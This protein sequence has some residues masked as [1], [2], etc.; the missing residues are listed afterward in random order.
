[1]NNSGTF[2]LASTAVLTVATFDVNE[3]L[4]LEHAETFAGDLIQTNNIDLNGFNL[5]LTGTAALDSSV[6]GGGTLTVAG[7]ADVNGLYLYDDAAMVV[8]GTVTQDGGF[9]MGNSGTD[10]TVL[11]IASGAVFDLL[12]DNSINANGT[13]VIHNAGLF[14]KA[15]DYGTS[16][17]YP[18]FDSTGTLDVVRGFLNIQSRGSLS[19]PIEGAQDGSVARLGSPTKAPASSMLPTA[20]SPSRAA[21]QPSAAR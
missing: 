18:T 11:S 9:T 1:M 20:R 15:G 3:S 4:V 5:S 12:T 7:K 14:E 19:G 8:K 10:N 21:G 6:Q 13:A 17:I 2:S 16:Y